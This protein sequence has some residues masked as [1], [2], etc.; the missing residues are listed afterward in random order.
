LDAFGD[1]GTFLS[2][3]EKLCCRSNQETKLHVGVDRHHPWYRATPIPDDN[4]KMQLI[5]V[6]KISKFGSELSL[7]SKEG[8]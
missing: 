6:L 1:Y 7:I 2:K 5:E 8:P 4:S 3:R